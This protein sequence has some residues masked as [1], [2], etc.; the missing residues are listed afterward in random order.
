MS[1][2]LP[3]T[4]HTHRLIRIKDVCHFTGISKSHIYLLASQGKF[5]KSVSLVPGGSSKAWLESEVKD[6]INGRIAAREE[7]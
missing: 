1:T 5:P 4:N 2:L 6:W 3:D 7:V